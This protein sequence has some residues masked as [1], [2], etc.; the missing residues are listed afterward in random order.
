[1]N[2][3]RRDFLKGSGALVVSF[4]ALPLELHSHLR[5]GHSTPMRPTFIPRNSIPG[6][7][8]LLTERSRHI[9]GRLIWARAC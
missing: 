2:V 7:Q 5:K 9:Q 8:S 4:S 1:M 6:S 3:S